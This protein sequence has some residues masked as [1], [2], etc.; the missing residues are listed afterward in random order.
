VNLPVAELHSLFDS[1]PWLLAD[2]LGTHFVCLVFAQY[3][4]DQVFDFLVELGMRPIVEL[5]FTPSAFVACGAPPE[6]NQTC[7]YVFADRGGY[8]GLEMPPDDMEDWRKLVQA[9]AEHFVGRYGLAE[10][11]QWYFE[12]TPGAETDST[13]RPRL[14]S[15]CPVHCSPL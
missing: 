2:C 3:N 9:T 7:D 12:V 15:N 8:K 11:S 14:T 6:F 5:S 4:V 13:R 10:V 1:L